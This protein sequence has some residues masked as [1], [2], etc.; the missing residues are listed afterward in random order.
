MFG[1]VNSDY[2][3]Y[4]FNKANNLIGNKYVEG[5]RL[6]HNIDHG[7]KIAKTAYS[8]VA[9]T[10]Q[11]LSGNEHFSKIN[12]HAMTAISG[13]D[14]IRKNMSWKDMTKQTHM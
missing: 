3:R 14:N 1:K 10:L 11:A 8:A 13:Y 12:K 6:L 9:P 2:V 5:K 4:N 7:V